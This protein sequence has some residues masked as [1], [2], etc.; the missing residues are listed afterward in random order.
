MAFWIHRGLQDM[1]GCTGRAQGQ[2]SKNEVRKGDH[3]VAF[4]REY[5]D[6]STSTSL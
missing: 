3:A 4:E 5:I 6:S 2:G 1:P